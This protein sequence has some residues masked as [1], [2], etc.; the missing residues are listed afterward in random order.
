MPAQQ[1]DK[2]P[3]E[4]AKQE[5]PQLNALVGKNVIDALGQPSDLHMVQ[6]KKLWEDHYRVNVF[7]GADSGSAKVA[8]SYFLVT[9]GDG[10]IVASNPRIAKKY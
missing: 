7:I 10:N 2:P 3:T 6:V 5:R 4:R 8:H 1:Q 9:D